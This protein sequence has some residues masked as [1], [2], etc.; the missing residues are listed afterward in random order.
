MKKLLFLFTAFYSLQAIAQPYNISFSGTGL[1]IVKVDNLTTGVV[2]DVPAGDV[3]ILSTTTGIPEVNKKSSQMKV[4]PNPMTDRSTLEIIPPV[5]GDAIIS[6]CDMS[7]KVLTQFKGYVENYSQGFSLSG[8]KNGLYVINVQGNGYQFSEKL[9]SNGNSNGTAS[10]VKISNNIRTVAERKSLKGS[11][12]AQTNVEMA[13]NS[14]D[15][16]K[17]TAIS[18]NN[19]TVITDIPTANKTVAFTFTECKDGDNNYYPVV[20]INTQLWMAENLKTTNYSNGT[21]IPLVNNGTSWDDLTPTSKAYCWYNDNVANKATY[22]ALYAWAAAMNGVASTT[23]NPSGIQGVCPTGWHLPSDAEWTELEN[24]LADNGYNYDGTTGGGRTKIAK[25]LAS[26]SGWTSSS[27]TGAVGNTDY[28]SYRNKSGFTALPGGYRDGIG[29]FST[30]GGGGHWWSATE[31][32]PSDAWYRYML[33]GNS[34]LDRYDSPKAVGF[35]V[36]CIKD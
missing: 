3:L 33:Y 21:P 18:G 13:Y 17:F 22:G 23:A 27:T 16:L 2:V 11:K 34:N 8:I 9:L 29:A 15:R 20:Q 4:Y 14:G 30:V 10:I 1:S 32:M 19:S 36:R 26:T 35:S 7:G 25:S 12:G 24:Y 28:P 31:G 6:V 5:S